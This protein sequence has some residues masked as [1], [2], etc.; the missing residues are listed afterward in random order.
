MEDLLRVCAHVSCPGY[1]QLISGLGVYPD[2]LCQFSTQ[3]GEFGGDQYCN[4]VS[5]EHKTLTPGPE[6]RL[7]H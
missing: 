5:A 3:R 6:I 7:E 4:A 1:S 2:F